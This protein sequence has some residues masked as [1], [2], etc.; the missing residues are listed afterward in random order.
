MRIYLEEASGGEGGE[1]GGGGGDQSNAEA[2]ANAVSNGEAN[3][4]FAEGVVGQG[5]TPE[6]FKTDKYKTVSDQAKAYVDL[7]S[8]FGAFTGAPDEYAF[9]ISDELKEKGVELSADDPMIK[10]FTELAKESNMSQEIA[11]KL[12]NMF[13]EDE[14]AKGQ[15]SEEAETARIA[16]EMKLL[17]DN[18]ENRVKN[19]ALWAAANMDPESAKGLEDLTTTAAGIKAVESLIA[20]SRNSEMVNHDMTGTGHVDMAEI[21][22]LQ[23]EKDDNGNRRMATDPVFRKMVQAKLAQ[24]LP[25]DSRIT[26]GA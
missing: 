3:F 13:I 6:W 12:V 22:K 17:G 24:A 18:A 20:K 25:G 8:K 15:G 9:T 16:D 2:V 10:S 23:F 14:F 1:G 19:I 11:N 5:P 4:N 7:E 26:I 21:T